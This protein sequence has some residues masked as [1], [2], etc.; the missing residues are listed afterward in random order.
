LIVLVVILSWLVKCL[1]RASFE[2]IVIR[3]SIRPG[4]G[5]DHSLAEPSVAVAHPTHDASSI[6]GQQLAVLTLGALGVVY[7]D[8]GTS[9]LYAVR[10]CF[11]GAHGI[12]PTRDNVLGV[13]SLIFYSLTFIIS[14]KYL[15]FVMRADNKGEGGIL[16]L[17][18][19]V[20]QQPAAKRR[21]RAALI[22]LGLFGAALLYGDGIITPA[23]SVLGAVEGIAVA[24]NVFEPVVV[25]T[26]IAILLGLF[27]IQR[28]GT[29][30][31]GVMF[32][33][34]MVVWFVTIAA[35][36]AYWIAQDT[37]VLA[38]L[39]PVYAFRF[40]IDTGWHGFIVLGSVFL[41]VTGGEAL[42]ADMG[43]FGRQ[44]I[45]I[46]WFGL[47]L[48]ALFINYLGQGAL[49]LDH[50]D[51]A[52][53]PFYLMAPSWGLYPLVILATAAAVIASQALISGAFSLTR[54]AIQ[55]GYSPRLD[56]EHTSATTEGQIYIPQVNTA[57]MLS[58]I[59]LVLGFRNSSAL[60]AAYGIAVTLTMVI[61]TMLA[62]LVARDSWGVSRAVA[63][64]LAAFFMVIDLAFLGSNLTKI[65][66]G[67][68][69]PLIVGALI[70]L[71]LSTWKDGRALLASRIN[72][73]IYPFDRFMQDITLQPPVRVPGTAVFM[74]SLGQGTPLTLLHNL[75][76]NQVLHER[77]ILLTVVTS[78]A[79]YVK[80]EERMQLEPLPHGFY[81]MT[82]RYGF[83]EQPDIPEAL[84]EAATRGFQFKMN[85]TT[86]FLGIETLLATERRGMALWRERLFVFTARNAVRATSFFRIPPERVVEI[87]IQ[88]EL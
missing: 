40:L 53:S 46:A 78:D 11:H 27:L 83:A 52:E 23:I 26:T 59:G 30:R 15:I 16:A 10:E 43:H 47:V 54:Q 62:Y 49:L 18:A 2:R 60:A 75:D 9:P 20:Q 28:H 25:P 17:M 64:S 4:T 35:M 82:L 8:I 19:L 63:G 36:G 24:T 38:A 80:P 58:T 72:E 69:F 5:D 73:R 37:H 1:T 42:Y 55:L 68:W 7:G 87:G 31:V 12:A 71:V 66:Y 29:H 45:R 74:T 51:A 50:P 6:H 65:A 86:F 76:H 61:T 56:I 77:V 81:R 13:L 22:A 48:P 14:I 34:V 67:G 85:R 88:V 70:Y 41:V 33:P 79:P 44:P 21:S 84:R 3:P 32:G 57:L 39:N